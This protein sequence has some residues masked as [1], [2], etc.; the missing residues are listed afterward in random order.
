M[1]LTLK[2]GELSFTV[3]SGHRFTVKQVALM[4]RLQPKEGVWIRET[5]SLHANG[6]RVYFPND[7]GHFDL[8]EA[9]ELWDLEVEGTPV[10]DQPPQ[11]TSVSNPTTATTSS[12]SMTY[13]GFTPVISSGRRPFTLRVNKASVEGRGRNGRLN[14]VATDELFV[15]ITEA[16]ANVHHVNVAINRQLGDGH[17]VVTSGGYEVKDSSA[18]QGIY[19]KFSAPEPVMCLLC[20]GC[21]HVC[22]IYCI[23]IQCQCS[24]CN[25]C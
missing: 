9:D 1:P 12:A 8:S 23:V 3:D 2:R 7:E 21:F 15:E 14:L 10:T 6:N 24:N 19:R 18:T 20:A 13:P 25:G 16:T 4:F 11:R 5:H 22:A 17:V